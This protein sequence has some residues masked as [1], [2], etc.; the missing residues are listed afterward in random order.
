MHSTP[1]HPSTLQHPR[2]QHMA[3]HSTPESDARHPKA[4][5]S[6]LGSDF[7]HSRAPQHPMAPQGTKHDTPWNNTQHPMAPR[8]AMQGPA[9]LHTTVRP[10][11]QLQPPQL[12]LSQQEHWQGQ[13]KAKIGRA[14]V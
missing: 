2:E 7:L 9:L 5:H 13:E 12:D 4:P 3:P 11:P 14:H 6:T 8:G 1:Q 10:R